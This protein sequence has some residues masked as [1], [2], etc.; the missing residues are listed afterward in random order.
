MKINSIFRTIEKYCETCG[1][2]IQLCNNRDIQR[3]RFC[4]RKCKY[5]DKKCYL[6]EEGRRNLI[7]K[8]RGQNPKKSSPGNKNSN[9]KGGKILHRCLICNAEFFIPVSRHNRGY[10]K[11]CSRKCYNQ[12]NK[13]KYEILHCLVCN[14]II[15][16]PKRRKRTFCSSSC[17]AAFSIRKATFATSKIEKEFLDYL[18]VE[19]RN[20][21]I[22]PYIV[23]G[24]R[25]NTVYEFLGDYYHGNP[26]IFKNQQELNRKVKKTFSEL[27]IKTFDRF[28]KLKKKG[29]EIKYIWENDWRKYK[30][31]KITEPK[32]QT[33]L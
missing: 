29:F 22:T 5:E 12:Y 9:W 25:G 2:K 18:G 11:W 17:R 4:S 13:N 24:I 20:I 26:E 16:S 7:E 28:D 21:P 19:Q 23:D 32:I 30:K 1:T 15:K 10:G 33:Y 6:S 3:K 8:N 31:N 27:Y 14:K